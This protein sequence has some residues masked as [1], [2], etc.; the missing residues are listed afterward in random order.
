M[1]I[2]KTIQKSKGGTRSIAAV[3]AKGMILSTLI[4]F[5]ISSSAF[6]V[7]FITEEQFLAEE[8]VYKDYPLKVLFQKYHTGDSRDKREIRNHIIL[9]Q[10]F[11]KSIGEDLRRN[12]MEFRKMPG[13]IK[14]IS[15]DILKLWV[16]ET[17]GYKDYYVGIDRIP[18]EA[19]II[20]NITEANIGRFAA[21]LY[22]LDTRVYKIKV[23]FP[24][25][26]PKGLS[27]MRLN[28]QNVV[29]WEEPKVSVKPVSYEIFINDTYYKT[30]EG[31]S[32]SV[33]R[34]GG[35]IDEYYVKAVYKQGRNVYNSGPSDIIRDET[36]VKELNQKELASDTY[37][38]IIAAINPGEWEKA[39]ILLYDNN[40][41][42][43]EH[44][45]SRARETSLNLIKFFR[46]IDEGNRLSEEK[47]GT[48]NDLE[49][50]LSFYKRAEEK[51]KVIPSDIDLRFITDLKIHENRSRIL[52]LANQNKSAAA[53]DIYN[54]VLTALNPGEWVIARDLL[55][56]N[57]EYLAQYLDEKNKETSDRLAK[58]FRDIDEGDRL[59][60]EGKETIK[61]HESALGFYRRAGEKA[62]DLPENIDMLFLAD[63]RIR[64]SEDR[65]ALLETKNQK[66]LAQDRYQRIM[67]A[68]NQGDWETARSL[69]Y[70]SR[71]IISDHLD[72]DVKDASET[73]VKFFRDVDEGDRVSREKPESIE[74]HETAL[75]FYER[76]EETAKDLPLNIDVQ[77]VIRI[78]LNIGRERIVLLETRIQKQQVQNTYDSVLT[79]LN[80][81][82]WIDAKELLYENREMFSR[83]LD[84]KPRAISE[85]LVR[86]FQDIDEG[87]RLKSERPETIK[88]Y[89]AA[90]NFYNRARAKAED[91]PGEIDMVFLTE[92]KIKESVER[93]SG[94]EKKNREQAVQDMYERILVALNP[95]EWVIARDLLY[96]NRE[97]LAQYLDEKNKETSDR[98][99]K[100]F[101]DIDE[102]DRLKSEGKETIKRHESALGFYRRAGEKAKDLP[103]NIDMLFLADL[104]IRESEDRIALLE[105]KNQKL[106]A[107]DRY[108]RIM[109]ALNQGDWET[110]RSLL[111]DSRQIISDHL[112]KDV[113]DASE[114]LVKFFRDV[115]EGDRVSR[116]KPESIER[117][118]T[119][120]GFYERADETAKGLPVNIDVL[121]VAGNKINNNRERIAQLETNK[122]KKQAQDTYDQIISGL[123]PGEWEI[124]RN[125]LYTGREFLMDYL[126]DDSK[127]SI[128]SLIR[129]FRDLD[130]GDRLKGERPETI[131]GHEAAL[132]F[133]KRAV[134]KVKN[135]PAEIDVVFLTDN[136]IRESEERITLLESKNRE[137]IAKDTYDRI[138]AALNPGEWK[139][140]R[141]LLYDNKDLL[142]DFLDGN[143]NDTAG[144][145][146]QFFRDLDEGDR[147][148]RERP[149]TIK[150][151]EAALNLFRSAEVLGRGLPA[152]IDVMFLTT[153]RVR[154]SEERIALFKSR[155]NKRIAMESYNNAIEMLNPGEWE[156]A[157]IQLYNNRALFSDYLEGENRVI[158]DKLIRFFQDMDEGDRLM[159]EIPESIKGLETALGF[160][161]SAEKR[162]R[163]LPSDIDVLFLMNLRAY[164][165]EGRIARLEG[166]N[167]Q[168]QAQQIFNR[169]IAA[170]NPGEWETARNMLYENGEFL[171]SNLKPDQKGVNGKLV[172]FFRDIDEGDRLNGN[173]PET[174]N[175]YENI[176]NFYRH[177][178]EQ[179]KTFPS[180]IDVQ[181]I[182]KVR[183]D[184]IQDII[185]QLGTKSR[186]K[187]SF[188]KEE[189]APTMTEVSEK[190][191]LELALAK[192]PSGES[193]NSDTQMELGLKEF[194][195]R[196]YDLA[197]N[198]FIKGFRKQITNISKGGQNQVR[199][200]LGIPI[201]CRGEVIFLVELYRLK[202]S[203]NKGN[204]ADIQAGLNAIGSRLEN[205]EGLWAIV[206]SSSKRQKIL[207][208]ITGFDP[209]SL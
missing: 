209:D 89:E 206:R 135:I 98:L 52:L 10:V 84:E 201:A 45:D 202:D 101:R 29:K 61:R 6:S 93:I 40:Q 82:E 77:P 104:R 88:G 55:Y 71:Q 68:L 122:R 170:L 187:S 182:S 143:R 9:K 103:E 54:R 185:D 102:G 127:R 188:R 189:K 53:Q 13:I 142:T 5:F 179:T 208:H 121:S 11:D 178:E 94:L 109:S 1:E 193:Y 111:Y 186:E 120:L 79:A 192:V 160:F 72:K 96:D 43:V 15:G 67:S 166:K 140:S 149:E 180:V 196:N 169:I 106:L 66:L 139:T 164:E 58:L 69:L 85:K 90:V 26:E 91:L 175:D 133:Y 161:R 56:D 200:I 27:V 49:V 172:R 203:K 8:S 184:K 174:V 70:D 128:E 18:L 108:Q 181:F 78:K 42:L 57:R 4:V 204:A 92:L 152:G 123:N 20:H 177:A 32:I 147:L 144:V 155:D 150:S 205:K 131:K 36:A 132:N 60:S 156:K 130:E 163:D 165:C 112:D 35:R 124:S 162:A 190:S 22:V 59:K 119:A 113:K 81:G 64:E 125:L 41:L 37:D 105:T 167:R 30:I 73:L 197:M 25:E 44:P 195:G 74:R 117:H 110:A 3:L 28:T 100:L 95:G 83:Y 194:E 97:Y 176:L 34:Q 50:A 153:Q 21:I 151:Y 31:T 138:I 207:Q 198:H 137:L 129:F 19:D 51:I 141:D 145:L 12:V 114:T 7:D 173:S 159:G 23:S 148:K 168:L 38:R 134:L 146:L 65:I 75:G 87:D 191:E 183:I 126:E 80:P 99:A 171:T 24:L 2:E 86:Y 154:E 199:G 62:K 157:R 158:S 107:Q 33:P 76:A 16:P 115:D 118:E 48:I 47:P 116:E 63:L 17:G 46:D 14:Q 136:R 39:K